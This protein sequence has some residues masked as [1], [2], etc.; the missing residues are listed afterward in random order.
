MTHLEIG[1]A[2]YS[3]RYWLNIGTLPRSSPGRWACWRCR[4]GRPAGFVDYPDKP[5]TPAVHAAPVDA[6]LNTDAR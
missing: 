3:P 6:S 4:A 1:P 5:A 2:T